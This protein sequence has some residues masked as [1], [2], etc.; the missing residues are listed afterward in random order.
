M[1]LPL[2]IPALLTAIG[3][4]FFSTGCSNRIEEPK[5][6]PAPTPDLQALPKPKPLD[7]SESSYLPPPDGGAPNIIIITGAEG[8]NW[9]LEKYLAVAARSDQE[10]M[11]YTK[12]LHENSIHFPIPP[13][14]F[15]VWTFKNETEALQ[16]ILKEKPQ[17]IM[18]GDLH[19]ISRHP[20]EP[21]LQIFANRILP[22][23]KGEF[24]HLISESLPL[25]LPHQELEWFAK[26]Q[27]RDPQ[28][29]PRYY[30]LKDMSLFPEDED[31]IYLSAYKNNIRLHGGSPKIEFIKRWVDHPD[32]M[33]KFGSQTITDICLKAAKELLKKGER[34]ITLNGANHNDLKKGMYSDEIFKEMAYADDLAQDYKVVEIDLVVPQA[35]TGYFRLAKGFNYLNYLRQYTPYIPE[36]GYVSLVKRDTNSYTLVYPFIPEN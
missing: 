27:H 34:I 17:A 32:E 1:A 31:A 28:K 12:N 21:S 25:D 19:R 35:Y 3:A 7:S 11:D 22:V 24:H 29:T 14:Q 18:F 33:E 9:P 2:I 13:S 4:A 5:N 8:K 20:G 30:E 10:V 36:E 16:N 26:H 6:R 23:L 15:S